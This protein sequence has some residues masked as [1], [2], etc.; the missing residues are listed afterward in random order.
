ML[1]IHIVGDCP[2]YE[3][4][5]VLVTDPAVSS[6]WVG[7]SISIQLLDGPKCKKARQSK[8]GRKEISLSPFY[9]CTAEASKI[10]EKV[11]GEPGIETRFPKSQSSPLR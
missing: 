5:T 8:V 11:C 2:C 6:L 1:D 4:V 9:K 7:P 10:V 3:K